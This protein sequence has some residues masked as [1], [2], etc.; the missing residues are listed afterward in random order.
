MSFTNS[1]RNIRH[2][3]GKM[4]PSITQLEEMRRIKFA[5]AVAYMLKLE[6]GNDRS[7]I[8]SI[9][10]CTDANERTVKN[11][12]TAKNAPNAETLV[13]LMSHSD[14]VLTSI[15]YLS[16]RE[17]LL[18]SKLRADVIEVSL[19]LLDL[20]KGMEEGQ[21]ETDVWHDT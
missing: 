18:N 2:K 7:M 19:Q 17:K 6:F 15:L 12:L 10:A 11:W 8:K 14:I 16:N 5:E 4:F 20:M 1:D 13:A 3:I 9:M 21:S